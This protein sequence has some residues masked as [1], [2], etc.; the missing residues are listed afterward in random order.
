MDMNAV[1]FGP[2]VGEFGWELCWWNP[3]IR[4]YSRQYGFTTVSAPESSRYLYEFADVF[5]PLKTKGIT[6]WEGELEGKPPIVI[7][8][9]YMTPEHEFARYRD[10]PDRVSARRS[11]R[12]L[13]PENPVKVADILCAFRPNKHIRDK[14]IP[15]KEYPFQKCKEVVNSLVDKGLSVACFGGKENYCPIRAR[16]LRGMSME[17]LCA[18]IAGAKCVIGPSSGPIHLASLCECPHVT[19]IASPHHTLEQ[20]YTKLWNPFNTP[21]KFICNSR[22]PSPDEVV[23]HAETLLEQK[24]KEEI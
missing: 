3:M 9:F 7:E 22:L 24:P 5:I 6:Y 23:Q 14:L 20:R 19:W 17:K 13:A 16:D 11:W 4:H 8:Q 10:E 1:Y 15:G 2:W 18:A 12:S 21:V